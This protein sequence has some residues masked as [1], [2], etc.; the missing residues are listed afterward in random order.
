MHNNYHFLRLLTPVLDKK[1][2]GSRLVT[3]FSQ[4]RDELILEFHQG[5]TSFFIRA[6]LGSSFSCLS[7]PASVHRARKNSVD[8]FEGFPGAEVTSVQ[9]F[10]NERAFAIRFV[11]NSLLFKMHGNRS[12]IIAFV[13]AMP[14]ELFRNH[15][16][17]DLQID[18]ATLN[19]HIDYSREAWEAG[20]ATPSQRYFTWGK[21][22]WHWLAAKGFDKASPD[23]R[24]RM[25]EE[26]KQLLDDPKIS[27]VQ[28][29]QR[30]A[31]TLLPEDDAVYTTTDP[32]KA[33]NDFFPRYLSNEAWQRERTTLTQML[34]GRIHQSTLQLSKL[35]ER[36]EAVHQD[37]HFQRWADLIMANIHRITP[38]QTKVTLEDPVTGK[39][40]EVTLRSDISP[41]KT[42]SIYFQKE[43]NRSKEISHLTTSIEKKKAELR[44]WQSWMAE[45]EGAQ[46]LDTLRA[47]HS[48]LARSSEG[49]VQK[50]PWHAFLF[51]GF[52]IRVGRNA[53]ANDALTLGSFKEDLW[54]HA[55]DVSGS[56]VIIKHQAGKVFPKDVVVYA[57]GLAAHFSRRKNETLCPV[58][59]TP[60]KFVR[61]RKGDPP[62]AVV[63]EKEKVLMVEPLTPPQ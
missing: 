43:K 21:P 38:G 17:A 37:H 24:W 48:R 16:T 35:Q 6:L 33:L 32:V 19:K 45:V 57:A 25:I 14:T 13:G 52:E 1:L 44:Q 27:V 23:E 9:Q 11:E 56:H 61:K 39:L 10:D 20:T 47:I 30:T 22:V 46:E 15:L 50:L 63:V 29:G 8:L 42:A 28:S 54:L 18:L 26:V 51:K 31:L 5:R 53:E 3:A 7:F 40:E 2:K 36:L 12:N 59:Y 4:A 60:K 62:G 34:S 55:K 49:Q 58:V 41:Q